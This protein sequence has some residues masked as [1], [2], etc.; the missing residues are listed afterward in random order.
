MSG[1]SAKPQVSAAS[2]IARFG[3]PLR[4]A[5]A[6]AAIAGVGLLLVA[7]AGVFHK[8]TPPPGGAQRRDATTM[9]GGRGRVVRIERP[10]FETAVGTVK[11]VH[12]VSLASKLLAKVLEVRVKAGQSVLQGDLLV[13]LD[14]ADLVARRAQ[15]EAARQAALAARDRS[16]ADLER[17]EKLVRTNTISRAEYDASVA[18]ARTAKAEVER[19]EQT[20]AEAAVMVSYAELKSPITGTVVDKRIEAGDTVTPGQVLV[21]L[22]DPKQM[23]M[24]ATVRESLA[25]RL[26]VGQR[27]GARLDSLGYDC[28]A[29]ISEIV[30][31]ANVASR[32]FQVKVTG[33]CPPG[34]YSGMF[35]RIS[36]PLERESLLVTPAAAVR[37]VGQLTLVTVVDGDRAVRRSVQLGRELDEGYEV[38]SGLKEGEVVV[39][40]AAPDRESREHQSSD[41]HS[42]DR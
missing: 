31:E 16:A 3:Q 7:L 28:E 37:K 21:S 2:L 1:S 14:D 8:K 15:A 23:Q 4:Y 38:L 26:E 34:I 13:K 33:P 17:A 25:Q 41:H 19:L 18:A 35:G 12:E 40:S 11:P 29:T 30:P 36:I 5:A 24:V 32:S 6:L 22:Y 10:R 42:S 27:I 9:G 20:L 39:L